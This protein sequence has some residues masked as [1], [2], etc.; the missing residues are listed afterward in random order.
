MVSVFN[1]NSEPR[2]IDGIVV[3]E[4]IRISNVRRTYDPDKV[5]RVAIKVTN[6][7][8]S[9]FGVSVHWLMGK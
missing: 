1:D 7:A 5:M 8:T 2:V 3:S 6:G 4:P 9:I